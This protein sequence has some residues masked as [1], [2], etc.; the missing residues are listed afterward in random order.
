MS[1]PETS[2][3]A[4]PV[5]YSGT[6]ELTTSV[7]FD[8]A[9]GAVSLGVSSVEATVA[10]IAVEP[11]RLAF[12]TQGIEVDTVAK[13]AAVGPVELSVLGIDMRAD[14]QPFSYADAIQPQA[15][16]RID[17]FSP[18][19]VMQRLG[20]EPPATADPAALTRVILDA[21][22]NMGDDLVRLT[23]LD[24]TLDD[25]S[26]SGS[27]TV[28]FDSAGRF[29]AKL[30][31]D[32]INLD[33]Y[34]Q[35]AAEG[36][37]ADDTDAAPIAMPSDLLRPLN[38]R[39]ELTLDSA[40]MSGLQFEDVVVTVNA[41]DGK[42]RINP[43]TSKLF[44]GTYSGDI[45]IITS[46]SV[47]SLSVNETVQGIDLAQLARAMFDQDNITGSIAGNF[48]LGGS[49]HNMA[50]IQQTL[51]GTMSFELKDGTYEGMDV[52]YELRRARAV[53]KQEPPPEPVLPAR[54]K[55]STVTASG[56]V[57][58][59]IMRND[60]LA[61]EL[62]FMKVTGKGDVNIPEG[63][64]DYRMQV[65]VLRKPEA[66]AGA[67]PEEIEDFTKTVI[68]LKITGPLASPTPVPDLEALAKQRVEEEVKEKLEEK[69]KDLF[70][71]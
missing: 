7:S 31:G 48:R 66:M 54:T 2:S 34:M 41:K 26:F 45:T 28:P 59:G 67:T 27:M 5:G 22:A 32:A 14:V 10:G 58:D 16:I 24:I 64:V 6:I 17:A 53:L 65:R 46:T 70:K 20:V 71:R 61:A 3:D 49:G 23:D 30:D 56:V 18:R 8:T 47:P 38:V 44:G 69:L 19:S 68:P 4:Q 57:K 60:D 63:T 50:E 11:T 37:A 9:S 51:G 13:T 62:P 35:P 52:W 39:G 12:G 29:F 25:T 42:L 1:T 40:Q 55:F 36:G 21:K 33:R 15:S 43:I